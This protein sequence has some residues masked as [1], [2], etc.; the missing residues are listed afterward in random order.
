M[1]P[2]SI[3][4]IQSPG[5][6][7]DQIRLHMRIWAKLTGAKPS[8]YNHTEYV[9]RYLGNRVSMGARKKGAEITEL[10]QYLLEHPNY[11][12]ME[13]IV[14]LTE[15]ELIKLEKYC[16]DVCF[17]N[18]RKYQKG[19]FPGWVAKIKSFGL[20][21][22]GNKSD[23]KVYCFELVAHCCKLVNRWDGDI[24]L[25]DI[26]QILDNQHYKIIETNFNKNS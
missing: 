17:I 25:V 8:L 5:F 15:A 24:E 20:L 9:V 18:H 6:L 4:L 7:P 22:W 14:D 16:E 1:K 2:G 10:N 23:K 11:T 19:M 12:V 21:K 13:P 26:Y 3:L